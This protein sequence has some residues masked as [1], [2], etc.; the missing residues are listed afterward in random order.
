MSRFSAAPGRRSVEDWK[1]LGW[2]AGIVAAVLILWEGAVLLKYADRFF[3]GQPSEVAAFLVKRTLDGYLLL[4]TWVTVYEVVLGFV[5]G[6]VLGTAIG[7]ALWWSPY[8]SRVLEPYAVVLNATPKI[9][10]APILIVWFGIGL[11]SKVMIAVSICAV[12]AWL[13]AFDG[14]RAT[15]PD[16]TDMV[17]AVGGRDRDVFLRIVVPTSLPWI[18]TTMR[19]NIGLALIGVITGEFLSSTQGLGYLVDSTAKLYQLSHT[20]AALMLI[21]ALAAVQFWL[22]GLLEK[23]LLPWAQEAELEFLS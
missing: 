14:V 9:V 12:V 4:Q 5:A 23:K 17:R 19:I 16:Q 18:L 1:V 3:F 7:W 22:V 6:T 2:Q 20:F 21:A 11:T 13:G 8:W 10:I 15:D